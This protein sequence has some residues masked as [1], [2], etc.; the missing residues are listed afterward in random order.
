MENLT[1]NSLAHFVK[2]DP[3]CRQQME[4]G[5]IVYNID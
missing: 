2:T 5:F 4:N 3:A 1:P